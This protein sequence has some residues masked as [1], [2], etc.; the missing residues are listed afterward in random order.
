LNW[1]NPWPRK[2]AAHS[3]A[4]NP[5]FPGWEAYWTIYVREAEMREAEISGYSA[6]WSNKG[7]DN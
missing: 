5:P 4:V 7:Y 3:K 6:F 2:S 1:E